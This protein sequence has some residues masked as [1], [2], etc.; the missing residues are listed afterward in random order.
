MAEEK[1]PFI[2]AFLYLHNLKN[3]IKHKTCI[4]STENPSFIDLFVTN[5]AKRFQ[6]TSCIS[7]GISDF[8]KMVVTVLKTIFTKAK[9]KEIH[10]R[11]YKNFDNITFVII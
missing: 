9:P 1:E 8:H 7:C 3:L 6:N 4:K 11:C 10:Y 5:C 2:G